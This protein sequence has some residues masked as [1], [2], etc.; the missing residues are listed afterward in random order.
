MTISNLYFFHQVTCEAAGEKRVNLDW[1]RVRC[2]DREVAVMFL[3]GVKGQQEATVTSR[4][5]VFRS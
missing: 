5:C 1:E 3:Q 4:T 2:F